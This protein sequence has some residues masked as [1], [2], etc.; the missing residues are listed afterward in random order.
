MW[1]K[2]SF[3]SPYRYPVVSATFMAKTHSFYYRIPAF[4]INQVTLDV[5]LD[6]LSIFVVFYTA[7]NAVGL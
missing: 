4:D 6:S 1:G 5:R 7:S 3:F 2:S